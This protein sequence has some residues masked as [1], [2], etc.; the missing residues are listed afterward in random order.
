MEDDDNHQVKYNS[1]WSNPRKLLKILEYFAT[2]SQ[3]EAANKTLI[4]S[5]VNLIDFRPELC[6]TSCE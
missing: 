4:L 2:V 5:V 3:E 1:G 6:Y